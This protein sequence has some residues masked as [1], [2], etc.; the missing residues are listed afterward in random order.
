VIEK[1]KIYLLTSNF[2]FDKI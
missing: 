1:N 2:D